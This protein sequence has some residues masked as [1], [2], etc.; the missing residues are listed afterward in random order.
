MCRFL[1]NLLLPEKPLCKVF[2]NFCHLENPLF[3]LM[4]AKTIDSLTW[5]SLWLWTSVF[6]YFHN[7]C[8]QCCGS[9]LVKNKSH[10]AEMCSTVHLQTACSSL[11]QNVHCIDCTSSCMLASVLHVC[12]IMI[13]FD[14]GFKP[15]F[16]DY[17]VSPY[18]CT[19]ITSF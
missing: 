1:E 12:L 10:I 11:V 13:V 6:L 4:S 7:D 9:S 8:F 18:Y 19:L 3:L 16:P 15:S 14:Y 2:V 17:Q 5:L